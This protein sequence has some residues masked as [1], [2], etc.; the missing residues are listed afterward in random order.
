MIKVLILSPDPE[1]RGGGVANFNELLKSRFSDD[2]CAEYF[3]IGTRSG[4][5]GRIRKLAQPVLDGYALIKKLGSAHFDVVHLNPSLNWRSVTRDSLFLVILRIF[6]SQNV[7]IFIRGWSPACSEQIRNSRLLSWCFRKIFGYA[8]RILVLA[9][10]FKEELG[11][12]GFDTEKISLFSTMFDGAQLEDSRRTRKDT[13]KRI[14]FLS[15]FVA[16]KG[17][18]ELLDGF[19]RI[20]REYPNARLVMAGRGPEERRA[21]QWVEE[22]DLMKVVMFPGYLKGKEKANALLNSDFFILPTYYGEGC[23]NAILEAM[24][25]GLPV[26]TTRVGGIPDVI[27]DDVNGILLTEV[28]SDEISSALRCLLSDE[29]LGNQMARANRKL[30]WEKYEAKV[31][32]LR[33]ESVYRELLTGEQAD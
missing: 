30:A 4:Q 32:T 31:V 29:K 13:E 5:V 2:V 23:P 11:K 26:I 28:T 21:R 17:I 7:L 22:H 12:T 19:S 6:G 9:T 25:A 16:E 15:R 33:L 14:L 24:G 27:L 10:V 20:V 1:Y 8:E 18:F 3:T